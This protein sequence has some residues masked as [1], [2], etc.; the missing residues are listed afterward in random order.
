MEQINPIAGLP[1]PEPQLSEPTCRSSLSDAQ[2]TETIHRNWYI[3]YGY[4]IS[5]FDQFDH[6][7]R[8]RGLAVSK[9]RFFLKS[10]RSE[11][12]IFLIIAQH[13]GT[14]SRNE[15]E[16]TRDLSRSLRLSCQV[17]PMIVDAVL[18]KGESGSN[19]RKAFF[20]ALR[21]SFRHV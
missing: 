7:A 13:M 17:E 6:Q 1:Y 14:K 15:M 5:R 18:P 16:G 8:N 2:T 12:A 4:I 3:P 19:E 21:S 9:V 20:P 10:Q 11:T